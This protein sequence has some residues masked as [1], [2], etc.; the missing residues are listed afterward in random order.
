MVANVPPPQQPPP[1]Q[2]LPQQQPQPPHQ[3]PQPPQQQPPPPRAPQAAFAPAPARSPPKAAPSGLESAQRVEPGGGV[4]GAG[5]IG[6]LEEGGTS[7]DSSDGEEV[8][9]AGGTIGF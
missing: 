1:P 7:S 2:P 3:Q 6:V 9:E 4:L 8:V 5:G